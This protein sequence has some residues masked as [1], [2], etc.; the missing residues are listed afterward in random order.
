MCLEYAPTCSEVRGEEEQAQ[1]QAWEEPAV[2]WGGKMA[3]GPAACSACA[4]IC[5]AILWLRR[6]GL[7]RCSAL[8]HTITLETLKHSFILEA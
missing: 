8:T 6:R 3:H 1:G 2:A 7:P 5:D 4:R